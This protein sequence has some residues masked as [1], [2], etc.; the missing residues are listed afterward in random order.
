MLQHRLSNLFPDMTADEFEALKQDIAARGLL[1]PIWTFEGQVLDGRHRL[2]ACDETGQP[3]SF[4]A[5]EGRDPLG[6]VVAMNL[7]RRHLNESQRAMVGAEIANLP[8]GRRWDNSANLRSK[9]QAEAA[10]M[11]RV[12][13]RAVTDAVKVKA[14]ADPVLT[15]A[16]RRGSVA[17][18]RAARLADGPVEMQ[19]EVVRKLD[20]GEATKVTEAM[21][22]I[23]HADRKPVAA[24]AGKYR[25]IYADPPWDYGSSG[26][27][28]DTDNYGRA[29]RH[30]PAMPTA[31]LL[32]LPVAAL[33]QDNAVLFLWV[34]SPML[35]RGLACMAAW[36]FVYKASF[37]WDKVRHNFGNYNSVRH[38][39]LLVGTKGSCLPDSRKLEHSVQRIERS[40]VHSEKPEEFRRIIDRL[41]TTGSRIELF[42]RGKPPKPWVGWG[43][44]PTASA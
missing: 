12:S 24:P 26:I 36:D 32:A 27:I 10:A 6:F 38:E 28:G 43:N 44:E 22:Q 14:T 13:T 35:D 39:L 7:K 29:A 31:E 37:V 1:D 9:S 25:V 21:R 19:R 15:A 2:R 8:E 17:V 33:A 3:A 16:V 30:Y 40:K 41:Y 42:A 23:R 4:R 11:V 34:T 5:Y 20:A 18:S